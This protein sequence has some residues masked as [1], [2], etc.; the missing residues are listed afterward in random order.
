MTQDESGLAP[1][2]LSI[3][4]SDLPVHAPFIFPEAVLSVYPNMTALVVSC[5]CVDCRIRGATVDLGCRECAQLVAKNSVASVTAFRDRLCNFQ[6]RRKT[7]CV[8]LFAHRQPRKTLSFQKTL[9]K[10]PPVE[11]V[12]NLIRAAGLCGQPLTRI[13]SC[14]DRERTSTRASDR[15][16]DKR[17]SAK[18]CFFKDGRADPFQK[19]VGQLRSLC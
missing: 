15:A 18:W 8:P 9:R 16:I 2:S 19:M 1:A 11:D 14:Q 13:A 4:R 12:R 5:D 6:L 7:E 10:L 3:R 17:S